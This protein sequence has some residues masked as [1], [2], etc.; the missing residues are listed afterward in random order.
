MDVERKRLA[1]DIAGKRAFFKH[2]CLKNSSIGRGGIEGAAHD[3]GGRRRRKRV[4]AMPAFF[5]RGRLILQG[6]TTRGDRRKGRRP[7]DTHKSCPS[8]HDGGGGEN[9]E[10]N[11]AGDWAPSLSVQLG[12]LAEGHESPITTYTEGGRLYLNIHFLVGGSTSG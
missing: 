4:A 2:R 11:Q 8:F 9:G 5:A 7:L 6:G 12:V 1:D 3:R 10:E